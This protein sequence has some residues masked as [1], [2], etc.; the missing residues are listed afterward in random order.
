MAMIVT[1]EQRPERIEGISHKDIWEKRRMCSK[2][3]RQE[4]GMFKK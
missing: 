1:F 3:L 4:P 2:A